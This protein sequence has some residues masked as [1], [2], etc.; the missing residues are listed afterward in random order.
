MRLK[1]FLQ[2]SITQQE[3]AGVLKNKNL[4]AGCEFEFYLPS[5]KKADNTNWNK[6][7]WE[8]ATEEVLKMNK[9]L[10]KKETQKEIDKMMEGYDEIWAELDKLKEESPKNTKEI[11]RVEKE[12]EKG[13]Q[14]FDDFSKLWEFNHKDLPKFFKLFG[15]MSL[16]IKHH[17]KDELN[18]KN[19]VDFNKKC[20]D[21]WGEHLEVPTPD[22]WFGEWVREKYFA[23]GVTDKWENKYDRLMELKF[24]LSGWVSHDE[25]DTDNAIW[26][27]IDDGSLDTKNHLGVEVVTP[28]M[29]I[30]ELIDKIEEVFEWMKKTKCWTDNTCGFHIHM[31]LKPNK[32]NAIDP[33]KLMLF[34]EEGLV[35]KKFADRIGNGY[36]LR[37]KYV[38]LNKDHIFNQKTV[39]EVLNTLTSMTGHEK[40]AGVRF[41]DYAENHVEFRYMGAK[42]YHKKFD[43]V[44]TNVV[45]YGHWLSIACDKEYKRKEYV[46][47]VANIVDKFNNVWLKMLIQVGT[48]LWKKG[49]Y[50]PKQRERLKKHLATKHKNLAASKEVDNYLYKRMSKD[51]T[52]KRWVEWEWDELVNK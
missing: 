49:K 22:E 5:I 39:K 12:I 7:K 15:D 47:K 45:N 11:K 8:E 14:K 42:D 33:V 21:S 44:K 37:L 38:H 6:V 13:E 52:F 34:T 29:Q 32:H 19:A 50:T 17:I 28:T 25:K 41:V 43:F 36:A 9:R 30:S 35:Y 3:F 27:V 40:N 48:M 20:K 46:R 2:E 10:N 4:L 16:E 1:Q 51:A 24:P 26:K 23:E 18:L 31:S